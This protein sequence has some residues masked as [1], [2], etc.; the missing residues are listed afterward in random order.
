MCKKVLLTGLEFVGPAVHRLLLQS[1]FSAS[2]QHS[3]WVP[4]E[5]KQKLAGLF[6][7][8]PGTDTASFPPKLL[9]KASNKTS[10][11]SRM[12]KG[13]GSNSPVARAT[14]GKELS[15]ALYGPLR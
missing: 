1:S 15:V 5:H 14:E 11:N 12:G 2:L 13:V 4:R 7:R 10:P 3:N 6:K 9:T 8:R